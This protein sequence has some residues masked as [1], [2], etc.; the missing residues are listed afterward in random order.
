L[1]SDLETL[2]KDID[3][4]ERVQGRATRLWRHL[5]RLV[6]KTG[7]LET[8]TKTGRLETKTKSGRLETK[9]KAK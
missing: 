2:I 3:I 6:I 8:K 1:Q 4:L 5:G 9:T 7:R